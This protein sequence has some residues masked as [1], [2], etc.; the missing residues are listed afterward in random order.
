MNCQNVQGHL[1]GYLDLSLTAA[2]MA[3]IET[4]IGSC[5]PCRE[6]AELLRETIQ[7]LRSLPMVETP[8]GFSQRVMSHVYEAQ[9]ESGFWRRLALF[10]TPRAA[11]PAFALAAVAGISLYLL[12]QNPGNH[13]VATAPESPAAVESTP[14]AQS[15]LARAPFQVT[16]TQVAE[17]K[18]GDPPAARPMPSRAAIRPSKATQELTSGPAEVRQQPKAESVRPSETA[19]PDFTVRPTPVGTQTAGRPGG[20]SGTASLPAE[21]EAL[22]FRQGVPTIEPFADLE[23]VVRRHAVSR[24][25]PREPS[26]TDASAVAV[27]PI[28]RLSAAIPDH[29]RPQTIWVRIPHAQFEEFKREILNLGIIESES[30]VPMLHDQSVAQG[31]GHIRVKL[32]AVPASEAP[33]SPYPPEQR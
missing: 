8:L 6:D 11:G 10:L 18:P 27:R 9:A 17:T 31:D 25:V 29:T 20:P 12:Q 1:S 21:P 23:I 15:E 28:E 7:Q 5:P 30:R 3:A 26:E 33:V 19:V 2:Q 14:E 13:I 4:H 16:E 22:F 24:L 32:T